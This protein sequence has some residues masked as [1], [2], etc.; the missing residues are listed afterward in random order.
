M[1]ELFHPPA[2]FPRGNLMTAA[3]VVTTTVNAD[4]PNFSTVSANID[5]LQNI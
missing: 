2:A 5:F 4:F 3:N 1:A